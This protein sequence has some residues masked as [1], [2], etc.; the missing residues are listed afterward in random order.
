[1][2]E[3]VDTALADRKNLN[4][5]YFIVL[6]AASEQDRQV[7]LITKSLRSLYVENKEDDMRR[8]CELGKDDFI[9]RKHR[10]PFE[11]ACKFWLVLMAEPGMEGDEFLLHEVE[12]VD[13]LGMGRGDIVGKKVGHGRGG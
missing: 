7:V 1:M 10:I 4:L 8:L 11:K 5:D 13:R 6:D 3:F 2:Q 9:W 12:S